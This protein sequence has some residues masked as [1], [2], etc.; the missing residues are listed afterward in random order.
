M[1]PVRQVVLVLSERAAKALEARLTGC[2]NPLVKEINDE[3][4]SQFAEQP[5]QAPALDADAVAQAM[6][7]AGAAAVKP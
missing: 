3:I 4:A 6:A 5:A 1:T 7:K 2:T